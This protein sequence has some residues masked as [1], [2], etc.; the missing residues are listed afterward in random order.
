MHAGP[1]HAGI[2]N[3]NWEGMPAVLGKQGNIHFINLTLALYFGKALLFSESFSSVLISLFFFFIHMCI[4][5]LGHFSPLP[6]P[7]PL[8]PTLPPSPPTP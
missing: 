7:P 1:L 2:S 8:P 3:P 4:Q 6:P 5:G